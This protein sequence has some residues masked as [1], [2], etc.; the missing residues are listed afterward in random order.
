MILGRRCDLCGA[1]LSFAAVVTPLGG[2]FCPSHRD[3]PQ[4]R[5]CGA[6]YAGRGSNCGPCAATAVNTQDEVREVLPRVRQV[7]YAMGVRLSPPVH[8]QLVSDAQLRTMNPNESGMLAGITVIHGQQVME[9]HIVADLPEVEFGS[10]VAHECM[11]AWLA[12]NG[13]RRVSPEI[14]EGICQ[15]VSYRWLRDQSDPRAPLLREQI[16][17]SPDPVYGAGFRAVKDSVF[18]HGMNSVLAAVKA[19]GRLP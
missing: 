3:L 11:H 4:C 5:L 15:L 17:R 14:E 7:L 19:T 18:R 2:A 1:I 9:V 13:Y 16:E 12:Q 6:P 10:V 8:V